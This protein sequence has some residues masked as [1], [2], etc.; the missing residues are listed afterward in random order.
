M[1][2]QLASVSQ[3]YSLQTLTPAITKQNIEEWLWSWKTGGKRHNHSRDYGWQ[4]GLNFRLEPGDRWRGPRREMLGPPREPAGRRYDQA[5]L[6]LFVGWH[7]QLQRCHRAWALA[8]VLSRAGWCLLWSQNL[9]S[10][11][12]G[13]VAAP[14]SLPHCWDFSG[15]E[16][17][18]RASRAARPHEQNLEES[19]LQG[20]LK[21]SQIISS[22]FKVP[23]QY[24]KES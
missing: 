16:S 15:R 11:R 22:F 8:R 14:Q 13:V 20:L 24:E 3:K 2:R 5:L 23:S 17:I 4:E 18:G 9:H 19:K 1:G 12:R 10:L 7:W 6:L 21:N